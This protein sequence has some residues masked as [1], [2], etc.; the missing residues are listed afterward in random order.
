MSD[1][2]KPTAAEAE[3]LHMLMEECGE[4]IQAAAKVLRHGYECYHPDNA[5][6]MDV[7]A[8]GAIHDNRDDLTD[9]ITDLCAVIQMICPDIE[10]VTPASI[11]RAIERKLAYAYHQ[12]VGE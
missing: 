1:F 12:E 3:R 8:R 11:S 10:E 4:V 5:P 2:R 7:G 9:E 6:S